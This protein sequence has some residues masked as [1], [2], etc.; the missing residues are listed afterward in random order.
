MKWAKNSFLTRGNRLLWLTL[1]R[2]GD[3]F[4]STA[5]EIWEYPIML[6]VVATVQM[7]F[8]QKWRQRNQVESMLQFCRCFRW[9][10]GSA[11]CTFRLILRHWFKIIHYDGQLPN[12]DAGKRFFTR[13][14]LACL[15]ALTT[16]KKK[17]IILHMEKPLFEALTYHQSP[18]E[19][20]MVVVAL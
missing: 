8:R 17:W 19:I 13:L 15:E 4:D 7:A 10:L 12:G 5:I 3:P 18:H 9:T 2:W 16:G 6:C 1:C 11:S 14:S 20:V